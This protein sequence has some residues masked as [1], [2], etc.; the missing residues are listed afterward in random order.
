MMRFGAVR[1]ARATVAVKLVAIATLAALVNVGCGGSTGLEAP[2]PPS[3]RA[4]DASAAALACGSSTP[5]ASACNTVTDVGA[6][7]RPVCAPGT[8]PAGAGGDIVDGTYVLTG[9]IYYGLAACPGEPVSATLALSS[10]CGQEAAHAG[11]PGDGGAVAVTVSFTLDAQGNQVTITPTC[12]SL[13]GAEDA[14]TKTYTATAS[15]LT[16][17][18]H[19]SAFGNQN[20]DR[21]EVFA[22]R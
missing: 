8:V 2:S 5:G 19:N 21:V 15:T 10:G 11:P 16:I 13:T 12:T 20:P 3:G 18:T 1:R 9:Q 17:F 14:P 22:K 6:P 7:I 4:S